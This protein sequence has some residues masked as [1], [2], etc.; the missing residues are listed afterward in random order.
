MVFPGLETSEIERLAMKAQ[1][2]VLA[3]CKTGRGIKTLEGPMGLARAFVRAGVPSV[4]A[5]LW[6]V[7]TKASKFMMTKLWERIAR[8]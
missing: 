8:T 2:G 7:D 1:F 3:A 6:D 4:I 5:S